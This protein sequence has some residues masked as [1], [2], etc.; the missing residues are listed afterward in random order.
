[1]DDGTGDQGGTP[2]GDPDHDTEP[3]GESL[4][5][6]SQVA[7]EALGHGI[8]AVARRLG[9]PASTLRTWNL[10][11]GIGPSH[12]SPGG[13]RR[14]DSADLRRLE[15]M[16]R[17]V[18]AGLPPSEAA[19]AALR[20]AAGKPIKPAGD[21][22]R[23]TELAEPA[24]GVAPRAELREPAEGVAPPAERAQR[25]H[26]RRAGDA[27]RVPSVA[28]LARAALNL[29]EDT[30]IAGLHAALDEHGVAWTWDRLVRPVFG[31]ISR[32]QESSGCGI[33]IEH[34][35]SERLLSA[36]S[37][38][39][40]RPERPVHPRAI[41]LA[42]AE[43]EQHSLPVY[44][45]AATL[46]TEHGLETR[47]LGART[48]Y[49]ALADAMRRLGP[50]VV[51]VW[52]QLGATG[53]P[54]P[55]STLPALRPASRVIVGG[56]GWWGEALPARVTRASSLDDAVTRIRTTLEGKANASPAPAR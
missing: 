39:T 21:A 36:L 15:E 13:H 48:P 22:P 26:G 44:A 1:M 51:F 38:L 7:G 52:S 20:V 43:D 53:D 10:R 56:P 14:Y 3:T 55:L 27:T 47:V 16:N 8:G 6:A 49:P 18:K 41:L 17:L 2:A 19:Q 42:C 28:A 25:A 4:G 29:D 5:H 12:R 11:Y 33:E 37:R 40:G 50:L 35:F 31:A 32:R 23:R 34:L 46:T 30:V 24:E 45:L 9:V 54:T